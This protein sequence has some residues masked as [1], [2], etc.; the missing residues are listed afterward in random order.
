M[1]SVEMAVCIQVVS[2]AGVQV[3][4]EDAEVLLGTAERISVAGR[5]SDVPYKVMHL[6]IPCLGTWNTLML[7]LL[8][9]VW[10]HVY[11]QS[12]HLT[13]ATALGVHIYFA[14]GCG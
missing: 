4:V 6:H 7:S 10:L 2:F 8:C 14:H 5:A 11:L 13:C 3:S 9:T 1:R 12:Q